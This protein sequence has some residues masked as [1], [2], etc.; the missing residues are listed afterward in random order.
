MILFSID[1]FIPEEKKKI[2]KDGEK[3]NGHYLFSSSPLMLI[4]ND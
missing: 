1:A 4:V 2:T 3:V